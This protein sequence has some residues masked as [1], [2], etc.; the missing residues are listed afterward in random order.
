MEEPVAEPSPYTVRR[1][2][3]EENERKTFY[4]KTETLMT[5]YEV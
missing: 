5:D 1:D 3:L 2:C 4:Q